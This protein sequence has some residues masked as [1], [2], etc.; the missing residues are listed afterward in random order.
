MTQQQSSPR[1][2]PEQRTRRMCACARWATGGVR[3]IL[4]GVLLAAAAPMLAPAARAATVGPNDQWSGVASVTVDV[5]SYQVPGTSATVQGSCT[6][7]IRFNGKTASLT[8]TI[9]A[10]TVR[11]NTPQPNETTTTVVQ[12]TTPSSGAQSVPVRSSPVLVTPH[13]NFKNADYQLQ[14]LLPSIAVTEDTQVLDS[15]GNAVP[16]AAP[17]PVSTTITCGSLP[18]LLDRGEFSISLNNKA[19]QVA[20]FPNPVV[21]QDT[22]AGD[23]STIADT[24]K[25]SVIDQSNNGHIMGTAT[26]MWNLHD[27]SVQKPTLPTGKI[28]V[29]NNGIDATLDYKGW[30]I[31]YSGD[32]KASQKQANTSPKITSPDQK[33]TITLQEQPASGQPSSAATKSAIGQTAAAPGQVSHISY[34]PF[35][36][37]ALTGQIG[38]VTFANSPNVLLV[39]VVSDGQHLVTTQT[40]VTPNTPPADLLEAGIALG[41]IHQAGSGG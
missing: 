5:P 13:P 26:I 9:T 18:Q 10:K 12:P 40:L 41:S 15:S 28:K 35:T 6:A 7:T 39:A 34:K 4:A 17:Q 14:F 8:S 1:S 11:Q 19:P 3:G 38:V 2:R 29:T 37:G 36:I 27:T 31:S 24:A 32:W 22:T 21:V 23:G 30:E 25:G 33:V 16:N 20:A